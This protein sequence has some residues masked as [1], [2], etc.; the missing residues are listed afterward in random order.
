MLFPEKW[1]M[2]YLPK[3]VVM[4]PPSGDEDI[5]PEP[6][7]PRQ[8]KE[9]KRKEA[10][11]SSNSEKKKLKRR[12]VH[13]SKKS[14]S[15]QRIPPDSLNRLRDEFEEEEEET[16]ELV[17]HVRSGTE[18]PQTKEADEEAV[19]EASEPGRDE[20]ILPRAG[21]ADKET[22]AENLAK[23]LEAAKSK[24]VLVKAEADERVAQHK[25][26]AEA[27]LDQVRNMVEHMKW[28]S[29]REALK[30]VHALGFDMFAKI[31]NA[32]VFEAKSRKLAFPKEEDSEGSED[33]GESEGDGDPEGDDA[34]PGE[35]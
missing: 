20:P 16:S 7:A 18:L 35:D 4:R 23:E 26:D 17:T 28:K 19:A 22:T 25:A 34:A 12:L 8:D 32:N 5:F 31:E 30:G 11:S 13:K 15:A 29:R 21:E 27:A 14:T 9:K 1:N 2:K 33:S 10:Q 6:P 3:D 24:V